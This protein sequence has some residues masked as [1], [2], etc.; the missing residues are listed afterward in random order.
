MSMQTAKGAPSP[1]YRLTYPGHVVTAGGVQVEV[2]YY[3]RI[4]VRVGELVFRHH[5]K[6]WRFYRMWYL[7]YHGFEAT[8]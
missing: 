2:P 4:Y 7:A 3:T 1:L 6:V 5:F 8:I